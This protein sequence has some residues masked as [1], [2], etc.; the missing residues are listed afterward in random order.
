MRRLAAMLSTLLTLAAPAVAAGYARP[1]WPS[2]A[3]AVERSKDCIGHAT[4]HYDEG[5]NALVFCG[6]RDDFVLAHEAGHAFDH[7][8]LDAGE[9]NRFAS[10][11]GRAGEPW[12]RYETA[13]ATLAD[14]TAVMHSDRNSLHEW[15]ADAY[16]ACRLRLDPERHWT[17]STDYQPGRRKHR[18]VCGFIARAV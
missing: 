10:L 9:R 1:A 14:G 2:P 7:L 13:A 11:M 4:G 8:H 3:P 17:S 15:F 16:A 5:R 18:R 6:V 12:R